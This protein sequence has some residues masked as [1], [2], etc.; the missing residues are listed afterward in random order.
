MKR[1]LMTSG[2]LCSWA[3]GKRIVLKHGAQDLIHLF[4]DTLYESNGLYRFLIESVAHNEGKPVPPCAYYVIP[5]QWEW[6][7]RK[8]ALAQMREEAVAYF[9]TLVWLCDGRSPW[10]VYRD[11]KF[12][13]NS[14]ADPCSKHL[15]RDL[16]NAW[17]KANCD[18]ADTITYFGLD[19]TEDHRLQRVKK[20]HAPWVCEAP[21]T[22]APLLNKEQ[23][24]AWASLSGLTV[25]QKYNAGYSHDNCDGFCCKAGQAHYKLLLRDNP[26]FYQWNEDQE[27]Q[28]RDLIGD[29]SILKRRAGGESV[30]LT[31][32]QLR[33]EIQE[34]QPID[35]FDWGGCG[36]AIE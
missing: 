34:N 8:A 32:K 4:A 35:E 18:P 2:G 25:S 23:M 10:E 27:S 9:D 16:L 6:E 11:V 30:P 26:K 3:T 24:A 19:W 5:P 17:R 20:L 29:Y 14:Q 1:L 28:A 31:L 15:K 13:G 7:R 33:M 36:C 22:E 12:I 21:M